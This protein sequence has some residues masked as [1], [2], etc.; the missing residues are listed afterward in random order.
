MKGLCSTSLIA[1]YSFFLSL[2]LSIYDS[3]F[4]Y[5]GPDDFLQKERSILFRQKCTVTLYRGLSDFI[6][7]SSVI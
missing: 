7:A 4:D 1:H 5:K 6:T 3:E 2:S